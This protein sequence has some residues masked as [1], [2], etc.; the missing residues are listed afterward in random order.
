MPAFLFGLYWKKNTDLH[1]WSIAFGAIFSTI[2]VIA[3]I[4]GY[5]GRE[6]NP[7]PIDAGLTGLAINLVTTVLSEASRRLLKLNPSNDPKK[8]DKGE[9]TSTLLYPHRPTWDVPKLLRF[10]E[11]PLTSHLLWKAMEGVNE[12]LA[13]PYWVSLVILSI[14]ICTPI[15]PENLPQIADQM[16]IPWWAEKMIYLCL[17]PST[18]VVIAVK[19]MPTSFPVDEE[20]ILKEGINPDLVELTLREKGMRESYDGTNKLVQSR[21]NILTQTMQEIGISMAENANEQDR[22]TDRPERLASRRKLNLLLNPL[23]D[24]KQLEKAEEEEGAS[25]G[26]I[27]HVQSAAVA[28]DEIEEQL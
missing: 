14:S 20:K 2:Y 15:L 12:P 7:I 3:I 26:H 4:F 23:G 24:S 21:R 9:Q 13:S 16:G 5:I 1:P 25:E 11:H 10:G 8:S 6:S 27:T 18:I 19:N 17:I 28:G 22:S